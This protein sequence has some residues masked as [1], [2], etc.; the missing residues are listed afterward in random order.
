MATNT[1][2][3]GMTA[4]NPRNNQPPVAHGDD[5]ETPG[6][7]AGEDTKPKGGNRAKIMAGHTLQCQQ[8]D[9][10]LAFCANEIQRDTALGRTLK[11]G[12]YCPHN[13]NFPDMVINAW[14]HYN[15]QPAARLKRIKDSIPRNS[16]EAD[17]LSCLPTHI[18]AFVLRWNQG[19]LAHWSS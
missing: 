10:M 8:L 15:S 4:D 6:Q 13:G 5:Q 16:N 14:L 3:S 17:F 12:G 11:N 7:P 18:D 2:S 9:T 19:G 1:N